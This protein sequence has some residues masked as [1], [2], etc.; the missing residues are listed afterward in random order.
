MM[1]NRQSPGF[2]GKF[3]VRGDFIS[4]RLPADFIRD[5]D[6]WLQGSLTASREVLG[7]NW[8]AVYLT[9][10]LWRFILSPGVCGPH[11][12]MGV[13]MPSVDR[14]GRYFPLT[15]ALALNRDNGLAGLFVS[16]ADWFGRLEHLALSCLEDGFDLDI[17]DK[18]LQQEAL[19]AS[20]DSGPVRGADRK[21][22]V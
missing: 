1:A 17:F 21:S 9:S 5:W 3:P 19:P 8:L 10:P 7:E 22:V 11:G 18:Q 2:F 16:A 20:M 15:L 4:R 6:G 12:W 14:V 13:L